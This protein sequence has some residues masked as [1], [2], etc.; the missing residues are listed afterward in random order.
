MFASL[1][2]KIREETGSDL[3]K[4]TQK[5]TSTSVQKI[6]TLKSKS[7]KDPQGSTSS[8]NS[9]VSSDGIPNKE[10]GFSDDDFKK[11]M[12]KIECE[13]VKKL[14]EKEKQLKDLSNDNE[15]KIENLEKEKFEAHKQIARLKENLKISEGLFDCC[16]SAN[17]Y[18]LFTFA[19]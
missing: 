14:E 13:Y 6:E 5:L 2:N 11:K 15:K 12:A 3:S 17:I 1:K 19:N 8:L 9:I 16:L 18:N 7:S 10:D 4:L